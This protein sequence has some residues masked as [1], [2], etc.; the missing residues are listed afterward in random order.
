MKIWPD[1]EQRSE[2]W[3]RARAGRPTASQFSRIITPAGK[4]STQWHD[5]A[6]DLVLESIEPGAPPEFIGNDDT[7]RGNDLEPEAREMFT[8]LMGLDDVREVGFV[9][10][11]DGVI[12]CSPDG[13][14][15]RDGK[16]IA[17]LEIKCPRRSAHALAYLKNEMPE[18]HKP[19][20]HGSM[21]VTGLKHWYYFSYRPNFPP[22][23]LRIDWSDYT[24]RLSDE[25]DSFLIFYAEYRK[26]ILPRLLNA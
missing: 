26:Q 25:L 3:F 9:T 11:D 6:T 2:E 7:D 21:A 19:Q 24:T 8:E 17:G 16:P 15:Y 1:I 20:V 23:V 13:L 18:K 5:F 22:L 4:R 10:R 14:I 12:G